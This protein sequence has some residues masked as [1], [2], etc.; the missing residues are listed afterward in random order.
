LFF[1]LFFLACVVGGLWHL[2]DT[3]AASRR[4]VTFYLGALPFAAAWLVVF[5]DAS[6]RGVDEPKMTHQ[7]VPHG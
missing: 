7:T 6:L 3:M 2:A 5:F 1:R 4:P